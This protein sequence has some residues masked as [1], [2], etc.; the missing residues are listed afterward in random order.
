MYAIFC[1][2]WIVKILFLSL[3]Q[4]HYSANPLG[5]T[6]GT[7]TLLRL[8]PFFNGGDGRFVHSSVGLIQSFYHK[9]SYFQVHLELGLGEFVV[10]LLGGCNPSPL[11]HGLYFDLILREI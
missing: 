10:S 6:S 1:R 4:V 8:T 7:P 9:R 3:S 5:T 2:G 11:L